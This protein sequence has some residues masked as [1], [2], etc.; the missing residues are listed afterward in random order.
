MEIQKFDQLN[1][2]THIPAPN[3]A[4]HKIGNLVFQLLNVQDYSF[5]FLEISRD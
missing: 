4:I 2:T 5:Y 1:F 3:E